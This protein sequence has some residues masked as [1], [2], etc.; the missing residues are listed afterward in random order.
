MPIPKFRLVA[1]NVRDT[2][3]KLTELENDYEPMEM[4]AAIQAD[5][6]SQLQVVILLKS[7]TGRA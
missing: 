2:Q 5:P 4:S 6:K 3:A 1:G 7:I